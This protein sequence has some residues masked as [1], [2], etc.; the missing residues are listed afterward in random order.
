MIDG[1]TERELELL[2]DVLENMSGRVGEGLISLSMV[3]PPDTRSGL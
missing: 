3:A 2:R 1:E